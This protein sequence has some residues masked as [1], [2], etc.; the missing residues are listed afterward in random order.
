MPDEVRQNGPSAE[1]LPG[2]VPVEKDQPKKGWFRSL[3]IFGW[4]GGLGLSSKLLLLTLLFV[5]LA[6][7]LI[8]VPSIANFRLNWLQQRL[9]AAQTA[10]LALKAAPDLEISEELA[11]E[12]LTN[13]EVLAIVL[14]EDNN[15]RLILKSNMPPV[16]DKHFDF[17][18]SMRPNSIFDAIETLFAPQG[19][20]ISVIDETR[21]KAE[22]AIQIIIDESHLKAAMIKFSFN[23]L[24]LS[25]AISLITAGLVYLVLNWLLVAPMRRLTNAIV[26]FGERPADPSRIVTPTSRSD[27]IGIAEREMATMQV[28]L[29]S[30]LQQ[31]GNLAA[32]GLAVSKINHDLRNMLGHAQLMSDR[33]VSI[34]DPG[35]QRLAPKLVASLD[36]AIELCTTTLKTGKAA[37]TPPAR[38]KISLFEVADEVASSLELAQSNKVSWS[39]NVAKDLTIDADPDQLFRILHNLVRNAV[40]AIETTPGGASGDVSLSALRKG[41]IV[42]FAIAD[43]GPGIPAA[44]VETLFEAFKGG[45]RPGSVGLGLAIAAELTLAHGGEIRLTRHVGGASF[46]VEIP[47]CLPPN[48]GLAVESKPGDCNTA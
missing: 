46:E 10:S 29:Q 3:P 32:L 24:S 11:R 16:I 22:G 47:D 48:G 41:E 5:M 34:K 2:N 37:E 40:E 9:S 20:I 42:T 15:R 45:G 35:V 13:A 25:I 27:E 30:L 28:Q 4:F 38:R 43:N 21:F 18:V 33:L 44:M 6:E 26:R 17:R 39:N 19:R 31:K 8:Y 36:R 23:V 12:L 7:V 1:I 14:R